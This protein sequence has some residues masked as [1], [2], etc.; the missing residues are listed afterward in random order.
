MTDGEIILSGV[1]F[2]TSAWALG[3]TVA[4][5]L[6]MR[7]QI[8]ILTPLRKDL[9]IF[10]RQLDEALSA[11]RNDGAADASRPAKPE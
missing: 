1:A 9:R 8:S 3:A 10:I 5:A 4:A 11:A 6:M 2:G 7:G